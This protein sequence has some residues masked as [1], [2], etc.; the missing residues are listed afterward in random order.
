MPTVT[1]VDRYTHFEPVYDLTIDG[2]HTYYVL[3]GHA[4]VLVHNCGPGGAP[5]TSDGKYAKRD[6]EPGRHGAG[7][8]QEV[9]DLLE[10]EGYDVIR[11]EVRVQGGWSGGVRIYDGA[12]QTP[13][14]LIGVEAKTD[15]RIRTSQRA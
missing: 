2:V 4:P 14:G 6:G 3:A 13:N 7:H 5:R 15:G 1:A 12:I 9:W 10:G 8:E 11:G